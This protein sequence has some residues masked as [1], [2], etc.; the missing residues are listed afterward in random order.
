MVNTL[1]ANGIALCYEEFGE[2]TSPTILLIA[3]LGT[4][5]IRWP[6][7]F[8]RRLSRKGYRVIRFDNRDSGCSTH[9]T[10]HPAPRFGAL[11]AAVAAGEPIGVP[12]TLHDMADDAI[13]LLDGLG[14]DRAHLVGRSMGGMIAQIAACKY[15]GRVLTLTS[16][17]SSTGN[18]ALPSAPQDVMHGLMRPAPNPLED[19]AG[20]LE[21]SLGFALRIAGPGFPFDAQAHRTLILEETRRAYD[22]GGFR[23]QVAAVAATG[24]LR[25][26]LA[27]MTIPSLVVHGTDDALI[28][29]ACGRD[30][31]ASIAGAELMLIPGM[32]HELPPAL[33]GMIIEA[34]DRTARRPG[35]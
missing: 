20:F 32:G 6:V 15:P 13:G 22:P 8:C 5:M 16:I 30:T 21:H 9:L 1:D 24:D 14:I 28:P 18:P 17:M 19:Q 29:D 33:D 23:R 4:Q 3:G 7:R 27:G 31:A 2:S 11:V 12:Y 26:L 10:N 34:I 35:M 25:P